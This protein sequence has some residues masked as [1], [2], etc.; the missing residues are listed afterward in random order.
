MFW[1]DIV[2]ISSNSAIFRSSRMF[3]VVVEEILRQGTLNIL[4]T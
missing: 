1:A 4:P 3:M 2:C